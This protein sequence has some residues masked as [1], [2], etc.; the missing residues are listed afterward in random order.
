MDN[1]ILNTP[2]ITARHHGRTIHDYL[3]ILAKR[4]WVA[5]GIFIVL[6]ASTV[7]YNFT[8]IPIYKATA[9]ILIERQLPRVLSTKEGPGVDIKSEEFYQTQYKLLESKALAKKI[10]DKLH[11]KSNPYYAPIFQHLPPNAD[12]AMRRQVEERLLNSILANVKVAPVRQSSL[13]D[14]SFSHPDPKLAAQ[15]INTLAGCYIEQ[16]MDM[17][18]AVSQEATV[19]LQKKIA[20]A[21]KKLEASETKLNQYK[22]DHNIVT[23]GDKE[24]ITAQ[25]LQQLN[26]DL[27]AAQ[28][29]RMEA[30]T[31]FKEVSQGH[32]ISDVLSNPLVQTLKGQ[33]AQ[34]IAQ[35]S[36]LG[37]KYGEKHPRMIRLNNELAAVRAKI[38]TEMRQ[39]VQAVKNEYHMAQAQEANLKAAMEAIK[40]ETQDLGDRTI[41]YQVLLRDVET[42]RALYE[43]ML[44]SLKET[45]A[46]ENLPSTNI[47]IV[48]PATVPTV[49]DK[50]RKFRNLL[51]AAVL[52]IV[53]GT[54]VALGLESMDTTLKTPDEVEE[55]LEIP[56]LA[57]ISHIE[58]PAQTGNAADGGPPELVVHS[59]IQPL[60]S[61]AYLGLRTSI[62]FST[63][64]QAPK[65]ILVTSTLPLEGKTLTAANLATAM[66]KAE[67]QVLLV[68]ADLR[69]PTLHQLFQVEREPGL[70]N[71]LVGDT[72]ELPLMETPVPGLFLVTCGHIPPN[73][74]ELLHSERMQEFLSRAQERFSRVVIDSPPLMSVTDAAI[75]ATLVEGALL[76]VKAE[77]VP[78]KAA[79]EAKNDLLEVQAPLLGAILNDV[80]LQRNGYYY[81]YYYRYQSYYTSED[82]T[83]APSRPSRKSPPP[84]GILGKIKNRLPFFKDSSSRRT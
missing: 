39:V 14:V 16:S 46:T 23:L 76:V 6:V 83:R 40:G 13:V 28:T 50:P 61:E 79:M 59:G 35:I 45:T 65:T 78:R 67:P 37:K 52:G 15:I 4:R 48:Y 31:R 53:F 11:L 42:N 36:E 8:A 49:P 18:F 51:L 5:I 71:F 84:Q 68:D 1:E 47:R 25:K 9:Q 73:P 77:T 22:R 33:E 30:E 2:Q 21:R 38:G 29:R 80:N 56:N 43:N 32:P 7:I 60:V 63:P 44:K 81:S 70:S 17:R 19:W 66:A 41:Q 74:S 57:M 3:R 58:V 64:G 69:R 54:A 20:E 27:V 10:A 24:A 75:L 55:W 26:R 62:L 72:D 82:D 34:I 12:A